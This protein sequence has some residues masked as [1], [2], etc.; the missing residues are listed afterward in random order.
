MIYNISFSFDDTVQQ[1]MD[2]KVTSDGISEGPVRNELIE[3]KGSALQITPEAL[4]DLS[5]IRQGSRIAIS[6][7]PG[8]VVKLINPKLYPIASEGSILSKKWT[9]SVRGKN[10]EKL[11]ALGSKFKTQRLE[12]G[13]VLL[14]PIP[15]EE[16]GIQTTSPIEVVDLISS[17]EEE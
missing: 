9:L 10:K 17:S 13:V 12:A 3:L 8:N 16:G 5:A 11:E 2:L 15:S 14:I 6:I 1:V 4:K 7:E